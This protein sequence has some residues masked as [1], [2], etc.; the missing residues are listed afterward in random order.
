VPSRRNIAQS[1]QALLRPELRIAEMAGRQPASF[2]IP[3]LLIS[4]P[5]LLLL[6]WPQQQPS[7]VR[8]RALELLVAAICVLRWL[9][10]VHE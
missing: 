8:S 4:K 3:A 2:T 6:P 1:R 5:F 7:R 9:K 10:T